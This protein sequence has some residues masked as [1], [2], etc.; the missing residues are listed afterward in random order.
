MSMTPTEARVSEE[1]HHLMS[2]G[3]TQHTNN[4]H[5]CTHTH[6]CS[7]THYKFSRTDISELVSQA[8]GF[9]AEVLPLPLPPPPH[10]I[11]HSTWMV[12]LS[13]IWLVH[14]LSKYPVK[15][16]DVV[17]EGLGRGWEG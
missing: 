14:A 5:T 3:T 17:R 4:L 7:G 2:A 16:K 9:I 12:Q 10:T 11:A 8:E 1:S 13:D 6:T 15:G